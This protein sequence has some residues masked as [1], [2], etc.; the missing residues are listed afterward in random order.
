MK[1]TPIVGCLF[2][3]VAPCVLT[4]L[5][6][7]LAGA[8]TIT[9]QSAVAPDAAPGDRS[10]APS[11]PATPLPYYETVTVSTTLNPATMMEAPGTVSVI[12]TAAIERNLIQNAADLVKFEPGVYVDANITRIG[13][14]G[15]NIRGIG[16]NRVMT[17]V[18]G[19]ETSE[20]FDFGPFN[21]QQFTLDL[22]TLKSAEIMRSSGS[23][24]Y[25]SDAL[26]GVVSFFTK[27]PADYLGGRRLS[28]A[29]KVLYDSRSDD[30]GGNL[31]IAGGQR[32]VL[33]SLFVS[34]ADG[35]EWR[36]KGRMRSDNA[37]R[38]ALNPQDRSNVQALGKLAFPIADGNLLR[39]AVEIADTDIVTNAL[40][41][42]TAAVPDISSHD[43]MRRQRVSL[44]QSLVNRWGLTQW[45]WSAYAQ[46]SDSDQVI[47]EA[48]SAAG[49]APAV[50]RSGTLN[51]SQ[52]SYG[53]TVQGRKAYAD[54]DGRSALFTFGAAHKHHTFD[55]LRDRLDLNAVTGAV[56]PATNLI[57]P[58]KYFPKS[59]VGE[60]GTYVQA[61]L[62]L[63]RLMLVP[64]VRYDRFTLNADASDAVY[65]ATLSP[66]PA[67]F[68]AGALSS[69]I[70]ASI[71]ASNA[72]TF[73]A[74]YA[75]GFRA[76]PYSAVNSGFTNLVGGYTSISNTNLA[77]ETSHNFDAGIRVGLKRAS[78]GVT[79][80]VNRFKDFIDQVALGM[81]PGTGLLEFQYQNFAR[82]DIRGI[83]LRGEASLT[84]TLR[85]R[86]SYAA[87][88]GD[89]VSAAAD[90]PLNSIAPNQGALGLGYTASSHRWGGD[91]TARIAR[92]QSQATAGAGL[93]APEGFVVTDLTGW[94]ELTR[95]LVLRAGLL[96]LTDAKYFEWTN[97]RGRQADA[98]IDRYSSP[99]I[100]GVLSVSYGW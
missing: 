92:G 83:E 26:G 18:D 17:Q 42:R 20:Q 39:A 1:P 41:L 10:A 87:I 15:F 72:V 58:S 68:S 19:I 59:D 90:V 34:Y 43:S 56:V 75:E 88:R 31:V 47:N 3:F 66:T 6:P 11:D 2:L 21:V 8:Q 23:A 67:D 73:H 14:N 44:D 46:R 38:T 55:M 93:F 37:S 60:T 5:A 76:P 13:L 33:G 35:H 74:Q 28:A 98:T 25:G 70:G 97:V 81:N 62:R 82:V 84:N 52:D 16:G 95:T 49:P 85:V 96:N 7:A 64:G 29:G 79:G 69:R 4:T 51:Y 77:A 71:R 91:L 12:G 40:S 45:S 36:N 9:T 99:G 100:S 86:A 53:G 89:N 65:L 32:R 50:N 61:E 78:V 24:V 27:D 22:D 48:R 94:T 57:L 63:G 80:F 54:A 30:R